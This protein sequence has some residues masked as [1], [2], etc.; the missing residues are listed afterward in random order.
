[1]GYI[2]KAQADIAECAKIKNFKEF[3]ESLNFTTDTIEHKLKLIKKDND[4][5]YN[6]KITAPESLPEVKG[7]SLVKCL[8]I[9]FDNLEDNQDLFTRLVSM[10]AHEISSVYD[11]EKAKILRQIN[12]QVEEKNNQLNQFLQALQIN[13][14]HLDN[15]DYLK[16][17]KQLLECCASLSVR[18]SLLTEEI[19]KAMK[20][21]V[22][23]SVQTRETLQDI[24]ETIEVEE[25]EH[26]K[27]RLNT[28]YQAADSSSDS[29][30]DEDPEIR[31]RKNPRKAKLKEISKRYDVLQ[32]NFVDAN[33]SNASLH[34]AFNVI[35]KNL[36]VLSLPLAELAEKLPAVEHVD[37]ANSK[38][39]RSLPD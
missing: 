26:R 1:M 20:S 30:E 39:S 12:E 18:R 25:K 22:D 16:L 32:K 19:P 15:F 5:V 7:A 37:D 10:K 9:D 3:K 17:P 14:L 13:Q 8:Q 4:F 36:Q 33:A 27:E 11:E 2:Q 24:E 35:I 29:S 31:A 6:E 38:V 34:E 21:I 23:V 28:N